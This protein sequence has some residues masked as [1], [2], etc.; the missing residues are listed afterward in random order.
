MAPQYVERYAGNEVLVWVERGG[1]GSL[2]CTDEF[3]SL[4]ACGGGGGYGQG[5]VELQGKTEDV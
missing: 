3:G 4:V 1:G 2:S 5:E